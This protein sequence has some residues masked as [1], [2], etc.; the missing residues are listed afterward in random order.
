[1]SIK[2][3]IS[4]KIKLISIKQSYKIITNEKSKKSSKSGN[5]NYMKLYINTK[6][7]SNLQR[8]KSQ[9]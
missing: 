8:S 9:S 7:N 3:N 5:K 1:M 4:N 6:I 2:T